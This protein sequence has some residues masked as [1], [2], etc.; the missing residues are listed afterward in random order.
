MLNIMAPSKELAP[1]LVPYLPTCKLRYNL[2]PTSPP[3]RDT[4]IDLSAHVAIVTGADT[5]LVF[6]A[7]K[8][9]LAT[10]LTY[11]MISVHSASNE[12]D[13]NP[14]KEHRE[15]FQINYIGVDRLTLFYR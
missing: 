8:Q 9:L 7:V 10:I 15:R 11:I 3:V 12:F 13:E 5:D 4:G 14:S 2:G 1:N 6:E